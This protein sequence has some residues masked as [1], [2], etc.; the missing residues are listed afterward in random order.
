MTI[1]DW[2]IVL[3]TF[4]GPIFAVQVTRWLDDRK[5]KR[6]RKFQIFNTLMA[7]RA[8]NLYLEHIGALNRIDVEFTA[9]EDKKVIDAWRAYHDHL[10]SNVRSAETWGEKRL[11]LFSDLLWEMSVN[12]GYNFDKTY[13]KNM[14]YS[15]TKHGEIESENDQIRKT[16]LNVLRQDSLPITITNFPSA[17]N[18]EDLDSK[19][20]IS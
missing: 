14:S 19:R 11:A 15:P 20:K 7:T 16:L 18:N 4:L 2:C 8:Y 1:S 17:Q 13:I 6:D 5:E 9:K 12:L 3:A 10:G